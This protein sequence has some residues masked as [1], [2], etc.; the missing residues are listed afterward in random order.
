MQKRTSAIVAAVMAF[1][2][3]GA[4]AAGPFEDGSVAY[5]SGD[6]A[7]ALRVWRAVAAGGYAPAQNNLGM[8]YALG[9]D[10]PRDYARAK[11]WYGRAADQGF[12]VAQFNIGGLYADGLGAPQDYAKAADW[13]GKAAAQGYGAAQDRLGSLYAEGRGVQQDPVKALMWCDLAVAHFPRSDY[14]GRALA[15]KHRDSLAAK[16][17]PGQIAEAQSLARGW[18]SQ[19]ITPP[20]SLAER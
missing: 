20:A 5:Q 19:M 18:T 6:Y 10:L 3:S 17:T 8:M 15:A 13:F 14:D 16:L 12:A 4:A 7:T 11:I 9:Q 2:L 1:S